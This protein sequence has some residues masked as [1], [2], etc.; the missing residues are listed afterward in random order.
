MKIRL[1]TYGAIW[2]VKVR[3]W[4]SNYPC[5]IHDDESRFWCKLPGR[6]FELNCANWKSATSSWLWNIEQVDNDKLSIYGSKWKIGWDIIMKL[7]LNRW[8]RFHRLVFQR[9]LLRGEGH[10][11][12][13][14]KKKRKTL[15]NVLRN[16]VIEFGNLKAKNQR[17]RVCSITCHY[18][19]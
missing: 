18:L 10:T 14:L 7:E 11:P 1:L 19:A 15:L 4:F 13:S 16:S 3:L 17:I 9:H 2:V 8:N 5:R 12:M 6:R